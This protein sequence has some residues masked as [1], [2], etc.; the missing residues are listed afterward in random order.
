MKVSVILDKEIS[1]RVDAKMKKLGVKKAARYLGVSVAT[2][3]KLVTGMGFIKLLVAKR[4]LERFEIPLEKVVTGVYLSG[5]KSRTIYLLEEVEKL[6]KYKV[7][8][9]D[10][11]GFS[12]SFSGSKAEMQK[13][14]MRAIDNGTEGV[15]L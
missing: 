15:A 9:T 11:T 10:Y 6:E 5:K 14:L 2:L 12:Y 3:D 13:V 8:R 7:G 1:R 4:V